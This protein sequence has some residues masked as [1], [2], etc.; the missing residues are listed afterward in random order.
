[1]NCYHQQRRGYHL[2]VHPYP[3]DEILTSAYSISWS[4]WPRGLRR[5]SSAACLLK[6]WVRIP[7]V[8][9][10]SVCCDCWV[11]SGRGLHD[12]LITRPEESY[13]LWYVVVCDLETSCKWRSWPTGVCCAKNE[14]TFSVRLLAIF[15]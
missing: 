1:M 12:E 4:R 14:K 7:P 11:L 15:G 8:A 2:H 5:T 3:E 10:M 6:L 13:R 9:W